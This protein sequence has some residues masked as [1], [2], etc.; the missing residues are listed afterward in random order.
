MH[1][2]PLSDFYKDRYLNL[3]FICGIAMHYLKLDVQENKSKPTLGVSEDSQGYI[4]MKT[5]NLDLA[6]QLARGG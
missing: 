4:H 2:S 3:E 5:M 6:L 1:G